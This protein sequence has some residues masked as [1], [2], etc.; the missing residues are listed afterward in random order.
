M[1]ND[2]RAGLRACAAAGGAAH[3]GTISASQADAGGEALSQVVGA[4]GGP[5]SLAGPSAQARA[6]RDAI[7]KCAARATRLPV[8][9]VACRASSHAQGLMT[10]AWQGPPLPSRATEKECVEVHVEV[11]VEVQ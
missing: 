8:H 10:H 6:K 9:G 3:D 1:L 11:H 4:P 7:Y 5:G 2:C